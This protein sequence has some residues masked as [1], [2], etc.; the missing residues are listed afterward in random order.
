MRIS[1][2]YFQPAETPKRKLNKRTL[3]LK[4]NLDETDISHRRVFSNPLK[5]GGT[6]ILSP[7]T[8]RAINKL[9]VMC[10]ESLCNAVIMECGHGGICYECSL[11]L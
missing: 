8:E 3:S 6:E 9:C 11:E 2:S 5:C 7:N 1:S 10:C 4:S